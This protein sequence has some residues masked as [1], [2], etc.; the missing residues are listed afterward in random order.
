[1]G[2]F[3][4]KKIISVASSV[5]SLAG[6]RET[7]K[8]Y[9]KSNLFST[10]IS[11]NS[12]TYLGETLVGNYMRGPGMNQRRFFNW[13]RRTDYYGLPELGSY[14]TIPVDPEVVKPFIDIPVSPA[15]LE[16]EITLAFIGTGF[17]YYAEQHMLENYPSLIDSDWVAEY[18][19]SDHTIT[20]QFEDTS[21][22]N[23]SAGG[24]SSDNRDIIAYHFHQITDST[25]SVITGS[26]IED[27][28]DVGDLAPD[29]GYIEQSITP[30]TVENFNSMNVKTT[31]T[32]EYSDGTPT[33][34]DIINTP[35]SDSYLN[36]TTLKT[37]TEYIGD[38]YTG[39][40][41]YFYY[42]FERRQ[43]LVDIQISVDIQVVSGVTI[44]TTTTTETDYLSPIY[45][46]RIDTQDRTFS[47]VQPNLIFIYT[48]GT[49]EPVLDALDEG[50]E[51]SIV[52]EYY[53]F[54]PIRINNVS[55]TDEPYA[56]NGAYD[57]VVEAYDRAT[58]SDFNE[59]IDSVEE[60]DDIGEIDYAYVEFGVPLNS[61]ERSNRRYIH[62]FL[63]GLI[64]YQN[65]SIDYMNAFIAG[66]G[67][68]TGE[69]NV[70]TLRIVTDDDNTSA[71]DVRISWVNIQ[72][73]I[74]EGSV[75]NI[76]DVV[77]E[78]DSVP[79]EW[80]RNVMETLYVDRQLTENTYSRL[81]VYGLVHENY[82]YG[83]KRVYT[84]VRQALEEPEDPED[85]EDSSFLLP[86][87]NPTIKAMSIRDST[88][89]ATENMY[90]V[91][92]SYAVYKK[93]WYESTFFQILIFI[94][95]IIIAVLI[96][97]TTLAAAPGILGTNLAVGVAIGLT[98]T[99][100]IVVGAIINAV[101]A[102]VVAKILTA[103]AVSIFG[104]KIGTIVGAVLSFIVSGGFD[105][106]SFTSFSMASVDNI[107]SIANVL[108]NSYNGWVQANII[109]INEQLTQNQ[110]EYEK[111]LDKLNKLMEELGGMSNLHFNPMQLT[112]INLKSS[113][114]LPESLDQFVQRTT[115]VGSDIVEIT[116]AMINDYPELSRELP[117]N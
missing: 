63:K 91:I 96:S 6:D 45:D 89:I 16:T 32:T 46:Y 13:A 23:F 61:L 75:G 77:L 7:R 94:A 58:G 29:T 93:K 19:E 33:D 90:L 34:E 100:A 84:D 28:D 62:T 70:T 31:I 17:S 69:P 108:A 73:E 48:I 83:G 65:T 78:V 88:Q 1:M 107:L 114:Y 72:E 56:S 109:D 80:T 15:G 87:H 102:I 24:Y 51:I 92:N 76:G 2:L 81:S 21:T 30:T 43:I 37:K 60:N 8:K 82:I 25:D 59:I 112:D 105:I 86:L 95:V 41:E 117:R 49:G 54:F 101:V 42:L 71:Y 113:G 44:T 14:A 74:I 35:F 97:P 10:Y 5:Y 115:L 67:S 22:T 4:T 55:I 111:S 12:K 39:S 104:D 98:G 85:R 57:D 3:S 11:G 50:I 68:F 9:L 52:P 64:P 99:A 110:T 40:T 20:I 106:N 116:L 79:L 26:L 27:I 103:G 36:N 38:P 47:N 18:N 66:I 53:P